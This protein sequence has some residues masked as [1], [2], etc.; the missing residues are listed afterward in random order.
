MPRKD[1]RK[2]Y[3]K[4]ALEIAEMSYAERKKVGA[5]I[6]KDG[7]V[8]S[9][10]YNGTPKGFDNSCE[11]KVYKEKY[12]PSV[13]IIDEPQVINEGSETVAQNLVLDKD[14]YLVS[15]P[16]VIHAECNA[17][18][19]VARSNDS[20]ENAELYVT[21]EPCVECAK[22]IVQSGISKVYYYENYRL[23]DGNELLK[24]AGVVVEQISD[25]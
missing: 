7:R 11:S 22:L 2:I 9:L 15:K 17:I 19:K 21:M 14:F 10:G 4:M 24:K 5:I 1:I 3:M 25:L 18:C 8:I 12:K 20:C 23:S 13:S 6:V 16:E